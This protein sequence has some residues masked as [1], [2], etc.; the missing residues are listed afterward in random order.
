VGDSVDYQLVD[1]EFENV[2]DGSRDRRIALSE[3]HPGAAYLHSGETYVVTRTEWEPLETARISEQFQD[4]AICPTCAA[5][6][7][8]DTSHCESCGSRLKRL[9]TKVPERVTAFQHDL[10]LGIT[11]NARELEPSSVYQADEEVQSTYAPVETDAGDSFEPTISYDIV[12]ESG[13]VHGQ[14]EYGDVTIAASTSK[15]WATYKNGGSDPLPNVF[16]VCG[17]EGCNGMIAN[18]GESAV[19]TNNVEHPVDESIAVRPA[20][21]FDTK[22][23]RVRFDSEELEHGFAHGLRVALQYIGGVSVRQVPESIEEEGTL[24][25]DSDEG[26][27]GIT[28]LLTQDDGQKFE[29]AV[30]IMHDA[31]SPEESEC[32]CEDGCPFCLYQYGCSEQNDPDSFDKDELLEL[33]SH[34]LHLEARNDD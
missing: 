15:Y 32:N 6:Y 2:S 10:P 1:E 7:D 4:A 24:V 5:E 14:F 22:A 8:T 17:I 11:P 12:D 25:Y 19:C 26:G 31:F 29:R 16:E 27:S 33:L 13:N 9:V 18:V 20:T 3:L 34:D 30:E 21:K 23:A 28:V